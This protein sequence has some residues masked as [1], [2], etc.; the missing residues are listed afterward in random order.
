MRPLH[1]LRVDPSRRDHIERS[2]ELDDLLGPDELEAAQ[3]LVHSHAAP[4][5]RDA[6]RRIF[7]L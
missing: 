7:V 5:E 1:G 3:T 4:P 6:G 2:L